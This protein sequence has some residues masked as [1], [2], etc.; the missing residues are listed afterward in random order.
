MATVCTMSTTAFS[1]TLTHPLSD[2]WNYHA[3]PGA[4]TRLTPGFSRISILQEADNL[5]SGKTRMKFPGGI[6]WEGQHDPEYFV[7]LGTAG[8]AQFS[9]YCTTRGLGKAM[10]W[11]HIH[12]F[13]EG[14]E[15]NQSVLRDEITTNAPHIFSAKALS[16][17][18]GFRQEQLKQDLNHL[19]HARLWAGSTTQSM[20]VAV[21]GASGLVGTQLCALLRVAGHK[22]IRITRSATED[23]QRQWDPQD[24]PENL[25]DGVDAVVHLAG[26]PIAGRFTDEHIEKVRDSRVGPT[27]KL[28]E[29]AARTESVHTFVCAS[30]V[31][32]YG[33]DRPEAVDEQAEYGRE[34][35]I[36]GVVKQ[37]E[38]ATQPARDAGLRVTNVRTGLVLAG[39]SPMLDML[40]ASVK[41][42]G[43]PLGDG[44]Q[45]FAWISLQDLVSIYHRALID[46]LMQGPVNAVAPNIV[47]NAE[48]TE[49]LADVGGSPLSKLK[50]PV[51]ELGPKALLG[52]RGAEELALADQNVVPGALNRLEHP[53][54]Y[55]HVRDALLHELGKNSPSMGEP[56]T[57]Y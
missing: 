56:A 6:V 27:K 47:T 9:D 17:V 40:T 21:T 57:D 25:L 10:G 29:L 50:I 38:D 42:G 15:P 16:G 33:H 28:A 4:V 44:S 8:S 3:S 48:F 30:A 46:P 14:A 55:P 31:G 45:H 39:G 24:P 2:L 19:A 5:K 11:R 35:V 54:R 12:K 36:G 20:T 37:W 41:V 51:P 49:V 53:F 1:Q 23:D 52:E 34:G 32:F 26:H 18:W 43:G 13:E 22:V 7:P